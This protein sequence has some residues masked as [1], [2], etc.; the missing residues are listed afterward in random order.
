M[1]AHDPPMSIPPEDRLASNPMRESWQTKE[2]KLTF[3][4]LAM[5]LTNDL[6]VLAGYRFT[7]KK[8]QGPVFLICPG[9]VFVKEP[10]V[11]IVTSHALKESAVLS[12]GLTD[13]IF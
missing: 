2:H 10:A 13:F 6:N 9:Q 7:S 12:I 4:K 1:I 8:S 3:Q 5:G 11:F